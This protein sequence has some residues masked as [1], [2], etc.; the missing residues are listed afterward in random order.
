MFPSIH[1]LIQQTA[2][3]LFLDPVL[4]EQVVMSQF[5]FLRNAFANP[6]SPVIRLEDLGK[7]I[8]TPSAVRYYFKKNR[9]QLARS[10]NAV[11]FNKAA[12][13]LANMRY[14]SQVYYLSRQFKKRF[15]SW[16]YK[17]ATTTLNVK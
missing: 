3:D 12:K 11:T 8:A 10:P 15:G 7:F 4:T 1:K 5:L 2:K 14:V 16:H 9:E 6:S 17:A 13:D